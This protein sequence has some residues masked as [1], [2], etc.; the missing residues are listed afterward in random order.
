MDPTQ[1][2]SVTPT[3]TPGATP[4]L[5]PEMP[6]VSAVPGAVAGTTVG[7]APSPVVN[8]AM[9]A[10]PS[11]SPSEVA[12]MATNPETNPVTTPT[13][14]PT[15]GPAVSTTT[16]ATASPAL[17]AAS[18]PLG[19]AAAS[20]NIATAAS[21]MGGAT[22]DA[23]A[24]PG[25][26]ATMESGTPGV[27][28]PVN[29]IIQPGGAT[30]G[31]NNMDGLLSMDPIMKPEPAP[32]PD[33][34][35][36][37]L[38]TPMKAAGLAPGSI[39]SAS[40]VVNSEG[41]AETSSVANAPVSNNPFSN[42]FK[43]K[44]TPSVAFNDPAKAGDA[45]EPGK[46]ETSMPGPKLGNSNLK[47]SKQTMMILIGLAAVLVVV[48]V[49]IL[50]V[51]LNSGTS[52]N[53][54]SNNNSNNSTS[55]NN[56]SVVNTPTTEPTTTTQDVA[57]TLSCARKMTNDELAGYKDSVDGVVLVEATFDSSDSL[58]S[59]SSAYLVEYENV[60]TGKTMLV[61]ESLVRT[62]PAGINPTNVDKYMLTVGSDGG[63]STDLTSLT[64]NYEDLDFTCEKL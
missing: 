41:K 51:Q 17:D 16:S 31:M 63:I 18:S 15:M 19:G 54:S 64:T 60:K 28:A 7:A 45:K 29:P 61:T 2:P 50:I 47:V 33:P 62:I 35:E 43:K 42:L 25:V 57:T 1:N 38:K 27:A 48:L 10:A 3:P 13:M 49:V 55:Q 56:S 34:V 20:P 32:A 44:Q 52:S 11:P 14:N 23:V 58:V 4:S 22:L 8:P 46:P 5:T 36:E 26:G 37:E 21:N 53:S 24:T 39:G 9:S 6:T 59:L 12:G 40:G 30:T